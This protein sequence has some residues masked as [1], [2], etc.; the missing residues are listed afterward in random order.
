MSAFVRFVTRR[1]TS[2]G[3]ALYV[4]GSISQKTTVAP[5]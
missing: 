5:V 1:S 3:S 4:R 2:S